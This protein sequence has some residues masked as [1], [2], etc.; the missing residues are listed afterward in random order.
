MIEGYMDGCSVQNVQMM[1]GWD[2]GNDD[3]IDHLDDVRAVMA[4]PPYSVW[5]WL[6]AR[7]SFELHGLTDRERAEYALGYAA[8][9]SGFWILGASDRPGTFVRLDGRDER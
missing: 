4:A 7:R 2:A 3:V 9:I 5:P 6:T 1:R 8:A